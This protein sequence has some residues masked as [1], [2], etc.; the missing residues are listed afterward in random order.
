VKSLAASIYLD[1]NAF[2]HR[3]RLEYL[4]VSLI[5]NLRH[6]SLV[7]AYE[8]VDGSPVGVPVTF[9]EGAE[10]LTETPLPNGS[11]RHEFEFPES[12][13]VGEEHLLII[14]RDLSRFGPLEKLWWLS[15]TTP[16]ESVTIRMHCRA[17]APRPRLWSYEDISAFLVPTPFSEDHRLH[18]DRLGSVE[19]KSKILDA[20]CVCGIAWDLDDGVGPSA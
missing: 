11:M 19:W 12:L 18:F 10:L 7:S 2:P 15:T 17:G 5:P 3:I 4:Y 16:V 6:V 8:V 13:Q 20:S 14:E 1:E 9:T